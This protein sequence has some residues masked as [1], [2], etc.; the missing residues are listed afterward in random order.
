MGL[1]GLLQ[2][3]SFGEIFQTIS[4]CKQSGVLT[5]TDEK[6]V[7]RLVFSEGRLFQASLDN[8][9]KLG[10]TLVDRGV[11]TTEELE[12]ALSTQ[13]RG[14]GESLPLG[15]ILEKSG[16]VSKEVLQV[17]LKRHFIE[18]VRILLGWES[19]SF[20]FEFGQRIKKELL[21]DE[22]LNLPALLVEA[23][24]PSDLWRLE[25]QT[26]LSTG[27]NRR[28][29]EWA[30]FTSMLLELLQPI[31]T[32]E[33][34]LLVLR[35]ASE[36]LNRSVIFLVKKK[37]L[38]GMGQSGL[39]F[40]DEEADERVRNIRIP[41][42]EPSVFADAVNRMECYKGGL[43]QRE[44]HQYFVDQIGGDWPSNLFL[45]PLS[46]GKAP[47]ALLYGDNVPHHAPL[48]DTRGLEA[49]IKV[50]G[51]THAKAVLERKPTEQRRV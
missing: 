2:N 41:L 46:D 24:R 18:V 19:G 48:R 32:N 1:N 33:T 42:S 44:W 49:F 50:A 34:A 17:E 23:T 26:E 6:G 9:R 22:G 38:I 47:F 25:L 14:N 28:R 11:I 35:Y 3:M 15:A 37:E 8:I 4:M 27:H 12:D 39:Q 29:D 36:V 40:R 10:S 5:L 7:G 30:L 51:V 13:R 43:D 21:L 20:H 45:V 16:I 31:S